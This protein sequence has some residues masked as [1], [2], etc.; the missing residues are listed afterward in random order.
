MDRTVRSARTPVHHF[1]ERA[2]T[3]G[4][5][6]NPPVVGRLPSNAYRKTSSAI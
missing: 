4:Q 3:G 6:P 1:E 5:G 2:T